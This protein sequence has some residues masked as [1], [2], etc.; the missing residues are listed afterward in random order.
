MSQTDTVLVTGGSGYIAGFCI[1]RLLLEDVT[2]RATMRSLARAEQV[3]ETLR[4]LAP[5]VER[6]TF[7]AADL[8]DDKGWAEAMAGCSHVLHVASPLPA[9]NPKEDDELVRPARDGALRV[10]KAA[11]DAGARRVV[12]TSSTAAVAYGRGGRATAFT[13][14]DWSDET[15]R[16]DTSA[17]ER[18]KILAERAAWEW[19]KREGGPLELVTICPGAVLGPVLSDDYSASIEIVKKLIDGSL[20]GLPRFGWPLVDVRDVADL[21]IRA[22]RHPAAAGQRY[23][24]AGQFYWMTDVARVLRENLPQAA[25]RTPRTELPSL[26]VRL[27]ALFDPVVRDRLFE[28]DKE[29][30]VSAQKARDQLGWSPRSNGD[31]IIDTARSLIAQGI[32]TP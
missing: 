26:L 20:P 22:M 19:Q 29:R 23:I 30:P 15:N 17:Y 28:L 8:N 11:R 27:S 14:D 31:A 1:A 3:R 4:S 9:T 12:M 13:E 6:V 21:H 5:N 25:K 7:F 18:S 32:V 10:L 24:A 2:V 16:S